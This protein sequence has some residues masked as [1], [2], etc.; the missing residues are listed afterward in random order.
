MVIDRGTTPPI[1]AHR[2]RRNIKGLFTQD[3]LTERS[4]GF[5]PT[6]VQDGTGALT[7]HCKSFYSSCSRTA[8]LFFLSLTRLCCTLALYYSAVFFTV[9]VL[10][11]SV[12]GNVNVNKR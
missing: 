2:H 5:F 1:A 4:N 9:L 12:R 6:A 10:Y 3:T 11:P 8:P 7:G